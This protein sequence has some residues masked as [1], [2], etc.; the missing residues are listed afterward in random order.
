LNEEPDGSRERVLVSDTRT[1]LTSI[2][3]HL[4][5]N[6]LLPQLD[7]RAVGQ[8]KLKENGMSRSAYVEQCKFFSEKVFDLFVDDEMFSA[9]FPNEPK[10]CLRKLTTD[11]F[12][13]RSDSCFDVPKLRKATEVHTPAK[14]IQLMNRYLDGSEDE[15]EDEGE[16]QYADE[17][18]DEDESPARRRHP[19]DGSPSAEEDATDGE[20]ASSREEDKG[21]AGMDEEDFG[22][23]PSYQVDDSDQE[24][25][26]GHSGGGKGRQVLHDSD[27]DD[28]DDEEDQDDDE[29]G[30][31]S[32]RGSHK[33]TKKSAEKGRGSTE[34]HAAAA[35]ETPV[36]GRRKRARHDWTKKE[37][38]ALIKGIEMFYNDT[39]KWAKIKKD[40]T[41][42]PILLART[43]GDL[44][45]KF[46]S[47]RDSGKYD[48]SEFSS[49]LDVTPKQNKRLKCG[50]N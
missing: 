26:H 47:M 6:T 17:D 33:N 41:L 45:D 16:E 49:Y 20:N 2:A 40:K 21:Q 22:P 11:L 5:I 35:S 48:F 42:G 19:R 23:G 7:P 36:P 44:K 28:D 8:A 1:V 43:N 29:K 18:E 10:E 39:M 15:D 31:S 4:A 27:N 14:L 24:A 12:A 3:F 9:A 25:W 34:K 13:E 46:R 32:K 30:L 50:P 37:T 38:R